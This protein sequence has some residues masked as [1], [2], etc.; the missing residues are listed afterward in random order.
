MSLMTRLSDPPHVLMAKLLVFTNSIEVL[1]EV[2]FYESQL[3]T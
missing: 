2:V 1:N 3:Y